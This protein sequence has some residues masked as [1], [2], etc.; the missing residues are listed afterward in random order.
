MSEPVK[1]RRVAPI[2]VPISEGKYILQNPIGFHR[3][4][5]PGCKTQ[6]V[7]TLNALA[8]HGIQGLSRS[9]PSVVGIVPDML[10]IHMITSDAEECAIWLPRT[11]ANALPTSFD[12]LGS[13]PNLSVVASFWSNKCDPCYVAASSTQMIAG[14]RKGFPVLRV[15]PGRIIHQSFAG[16]A[17]D[18]L[19][20]SYAEPV[21]ANSK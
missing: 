14:F 16:V 17:L 9:S 20:L 8:T 12:D 10:H 3:C 18:L 1:R 15:E 13:R 2:G 6:D 21:Q 19:P 11:S 4:L 7:Y 5:L